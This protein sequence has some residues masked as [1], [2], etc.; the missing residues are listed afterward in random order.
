[1]ETL[2]FLQKESENNYEYFKNPERRRDI[3]EFSKELSKYLHDEKAPN[4]I[5]IDRSPR[6]LWV[7]IDEYWKE[8]YKNEVRPNIYFV[9][10]DGF[11]SLEKAKQQ[12]GMSSSSMLLDQMM[13]ADTGESLILS[14]AMEIDKEIKKQ[15]EQAYNKLEKQKDKPLVVFDNCI[16]SGMTIVPVISYLN[17]NG[18][19]DIRIVIGETSNDRSPLKINKEFTDKVRFV[20]CNVFGRDLGVQKDDENTY[21]GYDKDANRKKVIQ[22]REEIRRIVQNKG[23]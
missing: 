17:K 20:A 23:I 6:P 9:N 21:S 5:M 4:V 16:H 10:P 15:F 14:K 3:Y 19:D 11:D 13:F 22:C 12:T 1:M 8:N 7:G 2:K 18:Y